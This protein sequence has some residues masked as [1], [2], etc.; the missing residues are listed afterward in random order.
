MSIATMDT[1]PDNSRQFLGPEAVIDLSAARHNLNCAKAAAPGS[2]VI[3]VIKSN[4]YGHGVLRIAKALQAADAFGL[5][6]ME[7]AVKLRQ[8][9]FEQRLLVLE[10]FFNRDEL[11]AASHHQIELVVHS[12]EQ[13]D[14]LEGSRLQQQVTCWMKVDT[15]M[16]RLGF[17]T[18]E[19]AAAH[20]RLSACASV[21]Q[22]L[23]LM[24]HLANA[25]DLQ[26]SATDRQMQQFLPL[27]NEFSG[28]VSVANSAALL[29]WPQTHFDWVRP[30]IM[31][32]GASPLL[33]SRGERFGLM[34]VMTLSSRL[35]AVKQYQS[36]DVIGY[37]GSWRCPESMPVG[38]VAIGYG[39]GYP[40]H[41]PSGT[42]LL[43]NGSRVPLVGRVSMDMITV[44]LRSQPRAKVGD[45]VVLW[46]RG[47]PAEEIAE[48][49]GT[50]SYELFC[51]VTQ[52]VRFREEDLG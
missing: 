24:T 11:E 45:P 48:A 47:L 29:C 40:R 13:L 44:D 27:T 2:K 5:A 12:R 35:I 3:A 41:T 33:G 32:Y 49:A 25:D 28:E 6:R 36:G 42:P 20:Q 26:D 43:L 34:P 50:I 30:G 8:A 46:G 15:G 1:D 21:R 51:G 17:S 37:G 38:V 18:T 22:P 4:A 31:L 39:D 52:R 16:H 19:A 14:L 9:G 10:G 7:E 23:R